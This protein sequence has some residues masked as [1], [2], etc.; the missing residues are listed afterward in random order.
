M[1][2][3]RKQFLSVAGA[4][5]FSVAAR[6]HGSQTPGSGRPAAPSDKPYSFMAHASA[7]GGRIV[8]PECKP[9]DVQAATSL[10]PSGGR[11]VARAKGYKDTILDH[12]NVRLIGSF[13]SA[14][15]EVEGSETCPKGDVRVAETSTS[16]SITK[17]N[18]ADAVMAAQVAAR[19]RSRVTLGRD[20]DDPPFDPE[21]A[22][23][24]LAIRCGSDWRELKLEL[25]DDVTRADTFQKVFR[26]SNV[27]G[28]E[29]WRGRAAAW[30]DIRPERL[31]RPDMVLQMS[32]FKPP[33]V[34]SGKVV[35]PEGNRFIQIP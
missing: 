30:P 2:L 25:N 29:S 12:G 18:I 3:T 9:I 8:A 32:I 26:A 6:C 11:G 14:V 31:P 10:P 20:D 33:A 13:E 1:L 22:L 19:L 4:G 21:S 17:I 23:E 35:D 34:P 27:K 7:F 15:S 28:R 16:V 5:A 24:G